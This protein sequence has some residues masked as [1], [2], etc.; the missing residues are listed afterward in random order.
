MSF[1][2]TR[3]YAMCVCVCFCEGRSGLSL[4]GLFQV[5][6]LLTNIAFSVL[7]VRLLVY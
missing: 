5:G 6:L 3:F 2:I 7:L 4:S 1:I